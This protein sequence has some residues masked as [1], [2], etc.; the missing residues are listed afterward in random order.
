MAQRLGVPP[1][2]IQRTLD[3]AEGSGLV[4]RSPSGA[5]QLGWEFFRL[6][7]LAQSRRPYAEARPFLE[8]L[9]KETGETAVLTVFDPARGE[10]MFLDSVASDFSIRFV[11]QLL[12]WLPAHAGASSHAI[13]AFRPRVDADRMIARGLPPLTPRTPSNASRLDRTLEA[14]RQRGYAISDDEVNLGAVGIA[15]PLRIGE[16]VSS[17]IGIILPRQ[18]FEAADEG[19][20]SRLVMR[21]ADAL[22]ETITG[23]SLAA[24]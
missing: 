13:L 6:G 2:S 15:A 22:A 4:A 23:A 20:L 11:P 8:R 5:W 24:P 7:A 10:R 19:R 9:Q 14:V 16:D 12:T 21:A 18:R 3:A 17:S 1:S